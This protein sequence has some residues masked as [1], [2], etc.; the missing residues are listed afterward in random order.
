MTS[1]VL[2]SLAANVSAPTDETGAPQW[3]HLVPNGTMMGRDGRSFILSNPAGL[4]EDFEARRLDLVVDFEHQN[5]TPAARQRGAIPAAGWIKSLQSR[6]DGIWGRVEWTARAAQ[7]IAAKE[8][9]YL[10]PTILHDRDTF[11]IRRL[12][13]ASLVHG[14]NLVLTALNSQEAQ[15]PPVAKQPAPADPATPPGLLQAIIAF[16]GLPADATEAQIM[17][18]MQSVKAQ[19]AAPP[20]PAKYM[21][22]EAV[23]ALMAERRFELVTASETRA[24]EKVDAAFSQGFIH[25]G[26]RD[27]ALALCRSDEAAFD[28]FLVKS[29]PVFGALLKNIGAGQRSLPETRASDRSDIADAICSQLGLPIGSLHK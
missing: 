11:E 10:S 19:M 3:V 27:W 1:L 24:Q 2:A 22:V 20:D 17:A 13:G 8:Y 5:D 14:P 18:A 23:Q 7:M 6:G 16:F 9:R 25:G 15:M 26:M 4:I 28:G 12:Q 29:G 21:P